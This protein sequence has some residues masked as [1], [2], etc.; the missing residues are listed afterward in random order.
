MVCFT[1]KIQNKRSFKGGFG[2][3]MRANEFGFGSAEVEV[4]VEGPRGSVLSSQLNM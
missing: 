3:R 4:S 2:G 1:T